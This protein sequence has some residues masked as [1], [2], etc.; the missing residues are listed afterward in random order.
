MLKDRPHAAAEDE[1]REKA[2]ECMVLRL[3]LSAWLAEHEGKAGDE[4]RHED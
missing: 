1:A 4:E 2:M 3:L